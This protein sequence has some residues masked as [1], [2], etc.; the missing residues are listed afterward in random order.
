MTIDNENLVDKSFYNEK[1]ANSYKTYN[2]NPAQGVNQVSA[3]LVNSYKN[4][5]IANEEVAKS[6]KLS[7]NTACFKQY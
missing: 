1:S 2:Y 7:K 5:F 4:L 3:D 6:E